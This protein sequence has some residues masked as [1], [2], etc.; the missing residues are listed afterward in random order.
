MDAH[1]LASV[2]GLVSRLWQ[3]VWKVREP[4]D[5]GVISLAKGRAIGLDPTRQ[6][7]RIILPAQI[8]L[9]LP[10]LSAGLGLLCPR[11][12]KQANRDLQH[13]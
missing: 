13:G 9:H 4:E 7:A 6:S 11:S 8:L 3:M 1:A 10:N 5:T 2:A 12:E